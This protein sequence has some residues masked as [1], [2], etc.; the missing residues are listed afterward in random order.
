MIF[1]LVMAYMAY[2][3]YKEN[4]KKQAAK[5]QLDAMRKHLNQ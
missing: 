2:L 1:E 4:K 3:F 5:R